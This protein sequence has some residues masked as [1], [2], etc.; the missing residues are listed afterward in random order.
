MCYDEYYQ[1]DVLQK[2]S[3]L[4]KSTVDTSTYIGTAIDKFT[5]L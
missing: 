2:K 5:N 1:K 3:G 4:Q